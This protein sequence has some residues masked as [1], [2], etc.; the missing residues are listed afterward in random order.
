MLSRKGFATDSANKRSFISM[1]PQV[2]PQVV[3]PRKSLRAQVALEGG[4]MLLHPFRVGGGGTWPL[5][6]GQVQDVV[7]VINRRCRL[8]PAGP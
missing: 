2:R 3:G 6:I 8:P 5:R 4:R 1:G 7:A